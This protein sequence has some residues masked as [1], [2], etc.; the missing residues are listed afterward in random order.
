MRWWWPAGLAALAAACLLSTS[1]PGFE[2]FPG[3]RTAEVRLAPAT[4]TQRLG[5]TL[6]ADSIPVT[7]VDPRDG[8]IQTPWFEA[9]TG[10]PTRQGPLGPDVVRVRGWVN[11]GRY[12]HSDLRVEIAYRAVRDPS[13]A[14]RQLERPLPSEHPLSIRVQAALDSLARQFGD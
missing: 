1:R 7:R 13:L 2:P 4:A 10:H 5:E 9:A 8:Y 6:R 14:E 12:G 3:A 11:P